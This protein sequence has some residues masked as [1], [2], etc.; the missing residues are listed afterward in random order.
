MAQAFHW[1]DPNAALAE[2]HRVLRPE[3][4]L[5][6]IYNVRDETVPLHAEFTRIFQPHRGDAPSHETRGWR[7]AFA[8]TTQFTPLEKMTVP[9]HHRLTRQGVVDRA[10]SIS[11][12]AELP[13]DQ[14]QAVADQVLDALDRDP[15]TAGKEE[16]DL[17]YR[18][19]VYWCQRR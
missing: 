2:L 17:P 7:Q 8:E 11:F 3:G 10:L 19:D 6:V 13:E 4:R 1:F 15:S 14:R 9:H 16:I 18:T 12:I 5:G